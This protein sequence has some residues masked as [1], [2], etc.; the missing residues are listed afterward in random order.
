MSHYAS[1]TGQN[2]PSQDQHGHLRERDSQS[3]YALNGDC[4]RSDVC[5]QVRGNRLL[6]SF[7]PRVTKSQG[8][9]H[10]CRF[11]PHFWTAKLV[12]T[13]QAAVGTT[14]ANRNQSSAPK[15]FEMNS[16]VNVRRA[17][18]IKAMGKRTKVM[19][20]SCG[21]RTSFGFT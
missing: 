19:M 6:V 3:K 12:R 16:R 15:L 11:H 5:W 20:S 4:W 17:T 9:S 21:P 13:A 7:N 10:I 14:A 18:V 1:T 8:T 2:S